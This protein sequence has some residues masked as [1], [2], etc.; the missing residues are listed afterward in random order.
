MAWYIPD[1]QVIELVREISVLPW[2]SFP[3]VLLQSVRTS[4]NHYL[5]RT[6]AVQLR[7]T[8]GTIN[9][10]TRSRFSHYFSGNGFMRWRSL[11][12]SSLSRKRRCCCALAIPRCGGRGRRRLWSSCVTPATNRSHPKAN[13]GI[14]SDLRNVSSICTCTCSLRT[15]GRYTVVTA[16]IRYGY[17]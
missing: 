7:G 12:P 16:T 13:S 11:P 6:V 8:E 10:V 5:K 3:N 4:P 14:W 9:F 17:L 15:P 2:E 1:S